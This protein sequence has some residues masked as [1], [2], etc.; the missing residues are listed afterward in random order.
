MK[1]CKYGNFGGDDGKTPP[2]VYSESYS[3][4][5]DGKSPPPSVNCN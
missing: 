4:P 3:I 2:G 1:F 5:G